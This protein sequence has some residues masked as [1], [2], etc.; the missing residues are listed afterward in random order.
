V[1]GEHLHIRLRVDRG[2]AEKFSRAWV[3]P[4]WERGMATMLLDSAQRQIA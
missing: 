1:A 4:F 3:R 2:D